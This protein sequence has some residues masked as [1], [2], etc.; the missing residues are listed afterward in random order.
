MILDAIL[1]A[2][3]EIASTQQR[4]IAILPGMRIASGH[5]VQIFDTGSGYKLWSGGDVDYVVI[6]YDNVRN[7][8]GEP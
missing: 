3:A 5:A 8:K 1:H 2:L 4:N 7:N 6:E